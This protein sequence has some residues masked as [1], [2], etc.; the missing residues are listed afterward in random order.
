[1]L[2]DAA[3]ARAA[4]QATQAI[5]HEKGWGAA[6]ADFMA[7]ATWQGEFTDAYAAQP[8]PDPAQFGMPTEDDGSRGDPL[9]SGVSNPITDYRPD[10]DALK[11]APTRVV[12]AVGIESDGVFTGR[13]AVATAE[14]LGQQATVFPSHHGGFMGGEF[15]YAGEPEAFAA[16]LREVLDEGR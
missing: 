7:M 15:G 12:V 8:A 5:Y 9:L 4:Q 10:V 11:A 13:T 16:R 6:M 14:A 1:M 3:Q 2:P